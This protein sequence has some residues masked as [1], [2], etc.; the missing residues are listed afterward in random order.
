MPRRYQYCPHCATPFIDQALHGHTR[1][2][3]PACGFIFWQNPVVGV[4]V[5]V[6]E[7]ER[8]VLGRRARGVYRGAWCI[9]CG[10]VEYDED[11]RQAAQREFYEETGLLV[12]VGAVYAVHSNFH[13]PAMHSV[14]IWFRGT[15]L[16][17]MLC[18]ADDLDAA[19]Y[20]SL[21]RL[22]DN[23]A[24]PTDRL[25]LAQLQRDFDRPPAADRLA[26]CC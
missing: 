25:V 11:V 16:G 14:G 18:P 7:G 26:D 12:Q 20:V 15:V 24:F 21:Q 4:A 5:I 13:N 3:C 17:G 8:I 22:P 10:Y 19:A 1:Q 23:L 9:P 2:V 6:L